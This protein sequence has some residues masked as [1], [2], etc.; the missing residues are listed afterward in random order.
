MGRGTEKL[1]WNPGQG[2]GTK[3]NPFEKRGKVVPTDKGNFGLIIL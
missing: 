1:F 2:G 3:L